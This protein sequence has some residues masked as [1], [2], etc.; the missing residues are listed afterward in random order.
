MNLAIKQQSGSALI[1]S[2]VVLL[3]MT[4]LGV[5]G[6]QSTTLEEKM[7][8]NYRD[9]AVAFEAAEAALV[10]AEGWI[11]IQTSPP[12]PSDTGASGVWTLGT[13]DVLDANLW[14]TGGREASTDFKIKSASQAGL[15]EQPKFIIEERGRVEGSSKKTSAE[16]G[17]V[18]KTAFSGSSYSYRITARGVGTTP[19]SV[20]ILQANYNM[21]F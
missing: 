5:Q 20:V 10:A 16:I 14:S 17:A 15:S 3:V 6:L 9:K 21:V 12:T 4:I 1:V 7:A 8:G 13:P 18:S 11:N 2:L 19:N